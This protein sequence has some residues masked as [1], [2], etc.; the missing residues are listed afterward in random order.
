MSQATSMGFL[1]WSSRRLASLPVVVVLP[2]PCRP[3]IMMTVGLPDRSSEGSDGPISS[4]SSSWQA[5]AK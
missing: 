5:D 2:E 4:T 1:P 3:T